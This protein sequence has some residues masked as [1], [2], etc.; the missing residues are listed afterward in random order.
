MAI[1]YDL[2]EAT[3]DLSRARGTL[4]ASLAFAGER[5]VPVEDMVAKL[6]LTLLA[7]I[8]VLYGLDRRHQPF[9]KATSLIA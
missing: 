4:K 6:L 2:E 1:D 3:C 5:R 8:C 7:M 9:Y